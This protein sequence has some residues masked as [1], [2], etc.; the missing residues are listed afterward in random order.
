MISWQTILVGALGIFIGY[1][2]TQY[3]N[4]K[5]EQNIINALTAQINALK[6]KLQQGRITADEKTKLGG[7]EVALTVLKNK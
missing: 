4:L 6:D 5:S 7:L 1:K 3:A 2:L